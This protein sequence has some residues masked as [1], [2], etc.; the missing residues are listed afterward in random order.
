ML[1]LTCSKSH[2]F[3]SLFFL[4]LLRE[5]LRTCGP[6]PCP[7]PP[8]SPSILRPLH[9]LPL[10]P[11][12]TLGTFRALEWM[13]CRRYNLKWRNHGTHYFQNKDRNRSQLVFL[14]IRF[15]RLCRLLKSSFFVTRNMSRRTS[16]LVFSAFVCVFV[17]CEERKSMCVRA[18]VRACV[19]VC[20]CVCVCVCVS[21]RSTFKM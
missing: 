16:F 2:P 20:V 14:M 10:H 19:R 13:H 21:T 1:A 17:A 6:S 3:F 12:P 9:L 11:S 5:D 4:L 7:S 18:C 15:T 8:P